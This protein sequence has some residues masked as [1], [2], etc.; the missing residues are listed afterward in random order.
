MPLLPEL[1]FAVG[2]VSFENKFFSLPP[3][4]FGNRCGTRNENH[5][6]NICLKSFNP[7]EPGFQRMCLL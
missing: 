4:G 6:E 7:G 5:T 1:S 3:M 2:E